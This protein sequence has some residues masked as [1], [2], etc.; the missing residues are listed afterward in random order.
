M[1]VY[2]ARQP[3][4]DINGSLAAYELLYRENE[5]NKFMSTLTGTEATRALVS[6]AVT[7]FGLNGLTNGKPAFINFTYPLLTDEFP[8]LLNSKEIVIEILEDTKVDDLLQTKLQEFKSKGY[9]LAIDDYTGE[10]C[11]ESLLPYVD[12]IKVDFMLL[13]DDI[14]REHIANRFRDTHIMLLA[15]KVE[16]EEEYHHALELGYELFQGYFFSKPKM[17]ANKAVQISGITYSRILT[18]INKKNP[19][20]DVIAKSVEQDVGLTYKLLKQINSAYYSRGFEVTQV[21]VALIKMGFQELRRWVLLSMAKSLADEKATELIRSAFL[22]ASFAEK[23]AKVTPSLK[24]KSAGAFTLGMFSML[25][26]ILGDSMENILK[27][28]PLTEE[29]HDALVGKKNNMRSLLEF[30]MQYENGT[31]DGSSRSSNIIHL[32]P[33]IA[34]SYYLECARYSDRVFS[35]I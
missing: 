8:C 4:I 10:D 24:T 33:K 11:W 20:W 6:D 7:V 9:I 30:V 32:E 16:T 15:E 18:E 28:I 34:F 26:V 29:V 12:I 14:K 19:D 21:K 27:D 5:Q 17:I 25:D 3:I 2:I 13:R 22:R 31:W 1:N 23:I 35:E